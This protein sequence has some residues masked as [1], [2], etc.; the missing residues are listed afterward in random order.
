VHS[1]PSGYNV[2]SLKGFA[3]YFIVTELEKR[4]FTVLLI[5][6]IPESKTITIM[7]SVYLN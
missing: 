2:V 7:K 3:K 1:T 6:R 4:I 5:I